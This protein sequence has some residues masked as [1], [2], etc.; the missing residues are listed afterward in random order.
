VCVLPLAK[1]TVI[2]MEYDVPDVRAAPPGPLTLSVA[3]TSPPTATVTAELIAAGVALQKATDF[4]AIAVIVPHGCK[5]TMT[6]QPC[7]A[8]SGV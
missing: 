8:G 5:P 4:A 6:P 3:L 7:P 2:D 1:S